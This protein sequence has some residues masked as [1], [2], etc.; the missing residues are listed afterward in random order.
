MIA[1]SDF[2]YRSKN[3]RVTRQDLRDIDRVLAFVRGHRP[4]AAAILGVE[5]K[6]L[7]NTIN[8]HDL[9]K[10]RWGRGRAGEPRDVDF[11]KTLVRE[12]QPGARQELKE[13]LMAGC[14]DE[15]RAAAVPAPE[16]A[17]N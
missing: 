14:P 8:N 16:P 10:N 3:Q 2:S 11:V 7:A 15:A 13:W 12:L 5:Y 17:L 1:L 6:W 4:A 9:L